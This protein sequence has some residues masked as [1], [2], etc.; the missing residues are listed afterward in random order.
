MPVGKVNKK[1]HVFWHSLRTISLA[2]GNWVAGD[3]F[4]MWP[5]L[6]IVYRSGQFSSIGLSVGK[7]S[8]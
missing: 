2:T 4:S 3:G 5:K 7:S 8:V 1:R 6:T